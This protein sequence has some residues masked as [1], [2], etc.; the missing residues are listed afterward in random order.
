MQDETSDR[1]WENSRAT[2]VANLRSGS[3][4]GA[5]QMALEMARVLL[6]SASIRLIQTGGRPA[7]IV[8]S[9]CLSD[10]DPD[11]ILEREG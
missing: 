11:G 4:T 9:S 10:N 3:T 2:L 8:R 7:E 5:S 1:R 6:G